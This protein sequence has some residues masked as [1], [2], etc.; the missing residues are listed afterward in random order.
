MY[1]GLRI[2]VVVHLHGRKANWRDHNDNTQEGWLGPLG[3]YSRDQPKIVSHG[4]IVF[5]VRFRVH[6]HF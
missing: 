2:F 5:A 3:N 1:G 6:Y 4:V